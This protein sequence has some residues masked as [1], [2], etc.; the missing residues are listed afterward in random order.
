MKQPDLGRKISELRKAKG[1]TQE[2]LVEKCNISVRTLQRIETGEVTPRSYT[3]KTILAAL[4]YD[5]STI[6]VKDDTIVHSAIRS[7][8][9]NL[10]LDIDL[11]A[12]PDFF[13]KQL[14]ISWIFGIIYFLIG[15]FE[16]AAEYFRY[17]DNSL[18]FSTALYV[19]I[20]LSSLITFVFFQRGFILI[21]KLF[22]NYLLKI[23]S[24]MLIF[25]NILLIGYDIASIFYEAIERKYILGS[26][27]IVFGC[28]GIL[29]GVSLWRL[30]KSIGAVSK[31]AGTFEILAGC[32]F[33][34]VVLSFMGFIMLVPAK[35]FVIIVLYKSM[36]I[37]KSKQEE[38]SLT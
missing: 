35:L 19:I 27:A 21:G 1:F 26:E 17:K 11:T 28:I 33:L 24:F 37:I 32:F 20:K 9:K 15:F 36:D 13:I 25:G 10:F 2:E 30:R 5:L 14:N 34:T 31:Y 23:A 4:D 22:K 38:S 12:S 8:K 18:I 16:G 3:I 7:F 29:Y 6:E